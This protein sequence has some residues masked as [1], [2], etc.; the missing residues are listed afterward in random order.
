MTYSIQGVI[1]DDP[2]MK[3]R[4]AQC[5]AQEGCTLAGI[6]SDTWTTA[7]RRDWA[8]AP[9]WDAAWE[10]AIAGGNTN[11][12]ADPAVITDGM[13]LTEVQSMMPFVLV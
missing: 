7:W 13:I 10:A 8:S 6:D 12:G 4:V 2:Y 11:P 9:G 1:A 3:T 5:A